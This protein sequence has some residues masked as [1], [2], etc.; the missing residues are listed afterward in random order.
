M[1][2]AFAVAP[3]ERFVGPGPW[4]VKSPMNMATTGRCAVDRLVPRASR[5]DGCS[6]RR[7]TPC[8]ISAIVGD[9]YEL[10]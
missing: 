4:G 3:R 8:S 1:V 9:C 10:G 2:N 6:V 7:E 5:R